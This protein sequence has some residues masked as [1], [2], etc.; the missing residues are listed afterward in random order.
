MVKN[1]L[2]TAAVVLL[3]AG[4]IFETNAQTNRRR[5]N[6]RRTPVVR[7][8]P[9]PPIQTLE[10]EV[11]SR[12]EDEYRDEVQPPLTEEPV[13]SAPLKT[14]S[15][16]SPLRRTAKNKAETAEDREERSL[17]DLERLTLAEERTG[18]LRRQLEE[19]ID[20]ESNLRTKLEQLEYQSR[21]EIIERE[22]AVIG[23]LR[24]EVE[25]DNRRKTIENEK[26]RINDQLAQIT[27]NRARLENAVTNADLL[28]EK[29][30]ARVEAALETE[31]TGEDK[32]VSNDSSP[33]AEDNL[34]ED[35]PN[36]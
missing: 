26:K 35:N 3:A 10:P 36:Q 17:R 8:Q 2:I 4:F 11:I 1:N 7:P 22:V 9:T 28:V 19:T 33:P 30:R 5:V 25:R 15:R 34:D 6:P 13:S 21:P 23:S 16:S 20:R 24:P 31:R 14:P 32:I 18:I 29:L 27:A 12:A